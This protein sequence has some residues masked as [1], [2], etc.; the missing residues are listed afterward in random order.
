MSEST[1]AAVLTIVGVILANWTIIGPALKNAIVITWKKTIEWER[2][3]TRI[4]ELEKRADKF[5]IDLKTSNEEL[6]KDIRAAHDKIRNIAP[7][8]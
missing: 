4:S 6:E 2:M 5:V 7:R 3:L 1:Q 8:G